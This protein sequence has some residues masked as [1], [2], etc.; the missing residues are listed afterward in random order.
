MKNKELWIPLAEV[1][2]YALLFY[3]YVSNEGSRSL[4]DFGIE[5]LVYAMPIHICYGIVKRRLSAR[6]AKKNG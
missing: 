1:A 4:F 3:E 2:V 5:A 6:K